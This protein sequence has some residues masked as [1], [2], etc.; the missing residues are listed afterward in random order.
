MSHISSTATVENPENVQQSACVYDYAQLRGTAV[1][2]NNVFLAERAVVEGN[3]RLNG[4][5]SVGQD[6][7]VSDHAYLN[8]ATIIGQ[9]RIHGS[10]TLYTR[11]YIT[12]Y[13][14]ISENSHHLVV[15]P[16]GSEDRYVNIFRTYPGPQ[17]KKWS[18]LILAGC[19]SGTV[20][21]LR[22]RIMRQEHGWGREDE[23]DIV[24]FGKQYL[25]LCRLAQIYVDKWES[26]PITEGDRYYWENRW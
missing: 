14:D 21:E 18:H 2:Q 20:K 22:Q 25:A 13:A 3:A 11:A 5:S 1:L 7:H 17:R 12:G 23:A 6:A 9:A 10:A 15:G 16:I 19:W 4:T 24:R 26:E 8:G